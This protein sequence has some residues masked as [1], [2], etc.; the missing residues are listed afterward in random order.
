MSAC[1]SYAQTRERRRQ[2]MAWL[3][4]VATFALLFFAVGMV[5]YILTNALPHVS[6]ELLSTSPSYLEE[7]IGLLPDILNTLYLVG[8]A[9]IFVIPMGVG[10]AIYLTEFAPNRQFARMIEYC[11]ETLAGIPSIIFGLVGML[12]FCQW[13]GLQTSLLAGSLTLMIMN[14]PTIIRTTQES[15]K[16]VPT[17]FREASLGLGATAWQTIRHVVLPCCWSGIATGAVLS[18]GRMLGESAAL[19]FTAGFAHTV[20]GVWEGLQ[21][22]GATLTVALYVYAKEQGEFEVAFVIAAVLLV[23]SAL[24]N[25]SAQRLAQGLERLGTR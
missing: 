5:G 22:P 11:V 2:L 18:V 25:W 16:A 12:V 6:W 7:R 23:L 17:T 3:P 15:L 8:A 4:R 1:L 10:T 14:L 9:L 13:M 21:A 24:I 19:L 20:H